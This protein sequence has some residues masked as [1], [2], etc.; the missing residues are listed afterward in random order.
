M[1]ELPEVETIARELCAGLCGRRI[2]ACAVNRPA[3]V[4]TD[5]PALSRAAFRRDIP[6][7]VVARV[8]RRA[9]ILIMDLVAGEGGRTGASSIPAFGGESGG[10]PDCGAGRGAK[11]PERCSR[12]TAAA[13]ASSAAGP[14][15]ATAVPNAGNSSSASCTGDVPIQITAAAGASSA[16]GPAPAAEVPAAGTPASP[17]AGTGD[18]PS[19]FPAAAGTASAAG[20][21]PAAEAQSRDVL[22]VAVRLG[23]SGRL[24]LAEPG[25]EPERHTHVIFDLDDGRRLF[26]TDPRTFGNVRAVPGGMLEAWP[27]YAALGPEPLEIGPGEFAARFAGRSGKM[28]ALLLDQ[29]V[30]AG[31]GN[32]YADESLFRAGVSP[33]ARADRVSESR[34]RRLHAAL[35]EVLREAIAANGSSIHTYRDAHGDSGAF[36]NSFRAYG[37]AGQPC[38]A[39]GTKLTRTTVAGRTTTYCRKCQK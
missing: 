10:V 19:P 8:W 12:K 1:P 26:F 15:S 37:R 32:I 35:Q 29:N 5:A 20:P 31:V 27:A 2:T 11:S 24:W 17:A 38:L 39:C 6:G 34:L 7:R 25:A 28:K 14:A 18:A 36:Q 16:A 21:A 23:M 3:S 33:E 9:K 4:E 22:H 13:G 30:V